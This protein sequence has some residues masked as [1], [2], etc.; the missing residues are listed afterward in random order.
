MARLTVLLS[1]QQPSQLSTDTDW[2]S[3]FIS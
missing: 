1:G 3:L 2:D